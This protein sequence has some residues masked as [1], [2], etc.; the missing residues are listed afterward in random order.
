MSNC[1]PQA[2]YRQSILAQ[3]F[4]VLCHWLFRMATTS[5]LLPAS[6]IWAQNFTS[7][8][9]DLCRAAETAREKSAVFW[10]GHP[11]PGNWYQPCPVEWQ[12]RSG[13]GSGWTVFQIQNGEVFGWRMTLRGERNTVLNDVI[14][15]EVDHAVRASLCRRAL[16]RWLDEGCASLFESPES[17]DQLRQQLV[18]SQRR[19]LTAGTLDQMDYPVSGTETTQLYA[20]GFSLVEYL[21][22]RGTPRQ[23]LQVQQSPQPPSRSLVQVYHREI[24]ELLHDWHQWEQ[25]R[26]ARGSRC[27]CVDCPWHRSP[28]T[29]VAPPTDQGAKPTLTIWSA[30]WCGPCQRFHQDMATR[31]RFRQQLES[32]Y[33]IVIRDIARSPQTAQQ[34]NITTVPTFEINGRRITGYLGPDWLLQQ[35][36]IATT[37]APPAPS[38][39]A[40]NEPPATP[41]TPPTDQ[42]D[43]PPEPKLDGPRLLAPNTTP[44]PDSSPT[45]PSQPEEPASAPELVP[46][47]QQP[48]AV[49]PPVP[50]ISP[51]PWGRIL[52]LV[53][54]A[55]TILS[56]V[57]VIGGSAATGGVGG[58]ALMILLKLWKRR[59]TRSSQG[60][61]SPS[62]SL[63]KGGAVPS[64]RAPF[65][66]QLDEAGELLEL[67]QSEGRVATLDTLRGMF[68]DDELEKLKSD[69]NPQVASVVR[70][71]RDAVDSRVDEVAP[72]TTKA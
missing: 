63:V 22:S 4:W 2:R 34:A 50:L 29:T 65:P 66:R 28:S 32:R 1:P 40:T 42:N 46:A 7:P 13:S 9:L 24:P 69:S 57:G 35:L 62:D 31:P 68:L 37:P 48:D 30:S 72:L 71:I 17:H 21:L 56:T 23:L 10:S 25:Q 44:P 64:L 11:L 6:G 58:V 26:S 3:V 54:T 53:P 19:V 27:D 70:R 14:P 55:L 20:E 61:A 60:K 43:A 33:Q 18:T 8:D 36:E 16:P 49:P 59:A 12:I 51:P 38:K 5:M 45:A 39:P 15:H 41:P 67:R 52:E 47:Q